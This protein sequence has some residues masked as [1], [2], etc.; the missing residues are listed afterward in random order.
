[1]PTMEVPMRGPGIQATDP[2]MRTVPRFYYDATRDS[3]SGTIYLKVVNTTDAPL[4]GGSTVTVALSVDKSG[5]VAARFT[6]EGNPPAAT[7]PAK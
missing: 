6:T 1:M 5:I 2:R 4:P 3:T 7:R